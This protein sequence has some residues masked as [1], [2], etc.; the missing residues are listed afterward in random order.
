MKIP[1]SGM[2]CPHCL[3]HI[4]ADPELYSPVVERRRR[5]EA[6][7]KSIGKRCSNCHAYQPVAEYPKATAR[8]DGLQAVCRSC[9]IL[10]LDLRIKGGLPLVRLTRA[11][12]QA[13]N[14]ALNKA[15]GRP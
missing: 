15:A 4:P 7:Y 6:Q 10:N 8:S 9:A 2:T 12:L 14:D 13:K 1:P 11:A 3:Q 5:R